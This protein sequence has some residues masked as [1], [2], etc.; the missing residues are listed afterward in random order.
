MNPT[1]EA[2]LLR[3]CLRDLDARA[4]PP[5]LPAEIVPIGLSAFALAIAHPLMAM[6]MPWVRVSASIALF[7]VLLAAGVR[8]GRIGLTLALAPLIDRARIEARIAE[9]EAAGQG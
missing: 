5:R 9:L 6:D 4:R 1:F 7:V 2:R 8:L 3:R